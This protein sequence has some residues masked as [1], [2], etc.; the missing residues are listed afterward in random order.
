MDMKANSS[1]ESSHRTAPVTTNDPAKR[2]KFVQLAESRTRNAIKAIR[3]IAKLGNRSA[4]EFSEADVRKIA[5]ALA[6]EIDALKA[7]ML[8]SGGREAVDFKL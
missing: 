1:H 2:E 3:V 5:G 6:K 7:R 4:Y 8:S